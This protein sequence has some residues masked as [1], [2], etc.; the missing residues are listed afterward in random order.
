MV[1][2]VRLLMINRVEILNIFLDRKDDD[3]GKREGKF[4]A[5]ATENST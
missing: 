3:S 2:Q 1:N 4:T 5:A